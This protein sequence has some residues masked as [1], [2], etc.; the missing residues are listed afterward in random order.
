MGRMWLGVVWTVV[1]LA[2]IAAVGWALGNTAERADLLRGHDS[3]SAGAVDMLGEAW[4]PASLP[5]RDQ[6]FDRPSESPRY[7]TGI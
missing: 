7:R 4:N 6:A 5:M 3:R 2:L 1:I